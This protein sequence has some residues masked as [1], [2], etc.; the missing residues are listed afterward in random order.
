MN[1]IT[2]GSKLKGRQRKFC[3][4]K[5]KNR[6]SNNR[7]Q[8]YL[9]QQKRGKKRRL[10]LIKNKGSICENC[11]YSKNQAALSFH[12]LDPSDKK[13]QID[14]R[15]CSNRK[16]NS[17]LKEANKCQLLCLNCHAEVHHPHLSIT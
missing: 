12:H 15:A 5:C 11:G 17:L 7:H 8:N 9:T 14:I 1:C 2:C 4:I 6:D 10:K 13:F 16:W 3:S